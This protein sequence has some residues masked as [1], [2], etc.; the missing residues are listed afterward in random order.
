M[1]SD[2]GCDGGGGRTRTS[3]GA[4]A[5]GTTWFAGSIGIL[6]EFKLRT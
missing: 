6:E 4:A 5:A 3:M 2:G 1:T